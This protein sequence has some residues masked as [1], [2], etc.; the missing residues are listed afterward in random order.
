MKSP[1][2][3]YPENEPLVLIRASQVRIC[4]GNHCAAALLSYFGYW[5]DVRLNQM[6]QA[7]HA[8]KMAALHGDT[9]TQETT[10][11]QYHT[12][13]D[14]EAGLLHLYG[15]KTIRAAVALLV[16]KEFLSL[17][18]NPNQRYRFDR[19]HYFLFHPDKVQAEICGVTHE[20]KMPDQENTP[21]AGLEGTD[22]PEFSSQVIDISDEAKMPDPEGHS[23]AWSGKNAAWSGKNTSPI[24]EITS[25]ITP[26]ITSE[27]ESTRTHETVEPSANET[28]NV[29]QV[30]RSA[31][32]NLESR[33][34]PTPSTRCPADFVPGTSIRAWA[35]KDCPSVD[36]DQALDAFRDYEFGR[37]YTDWN[38]RLKTWIRTEAKQGG[39]HQSSRRHPNTPDLAEV[40][41]LVKAQ[42]EKERNHGTP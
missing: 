28:G 9:G 36:Y 38:A 1:C 19:T 42:E 20:V 14:I 13:E 5:H 37:P 2:I 33:F 8:N 22:S 4:Q 29:S 3:A 39:N 24:A 27:R 34:S 17:H 18:E 6:K 25:E 7:E 32:D 26:E 35:A 41:A 31:I 10:L 15:R 30:N 23:A 40:E 16:R 11:L 12:E 21:M